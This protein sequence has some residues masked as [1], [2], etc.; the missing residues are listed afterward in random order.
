MEDKDGCEMLT[1]CQ[2]VLVF[3][4]VFREI[5][6]KEKSSPN[7]ALALAMSQRA[8]KPADCG[9]EVVTV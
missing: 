5:S 4:K 9:A 3:S 8:L 1:A 7:P 2:T 6:G